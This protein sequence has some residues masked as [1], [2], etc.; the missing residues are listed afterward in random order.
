MMNFSVFKTFF[1]NPSFLSHYTF[2]LTNLCV[3]ILVVSLKERS[4][5]INPDAVG[6]R[7]YCCLWS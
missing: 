1:N 3:Q 7:G 5:I 2:R 6:L 4:S